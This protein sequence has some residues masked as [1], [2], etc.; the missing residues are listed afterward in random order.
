MAITDAAAARKPAN[1]NKAAILAAL[2]V[3]GSL[4]AS[5]QWNAGHA[6]ALVYRCKNTSSGTT[7][8]VKVDL[9]RNT[10]DSYPAA[11]TPGSISWHDVKEGANYD[12]NRAT[13]ALTQVNSSSMGGTLWFHR[14]TAGG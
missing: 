9:D 13:G 8:D 7:W 10:V 5:S 2:I 14:C 6:A 11:I 1:F 3:A 12:L 4:L